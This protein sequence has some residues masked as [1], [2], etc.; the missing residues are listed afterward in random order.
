MNVR[1]AQL[2]SFTDGTWYNDQ[3]EMNEYTVKLWLITNTYSEQEQNIAIR[4]A[5]YF[6]FDQLKNTI[7]INQSDGPKAK[8]LMKVGLNVT[9]LPGEPA[10]QLI[11]IMLFYKLNAIMEDRIKAIEI[12]IST[13]DGVVY[14]HNENE[15]SKDLIQP[16]WWTTIDLSHS[17]LE[18][19]SS[20]KVLLITHNTV[21]RDLDLEWPEDKV[22]ADAGNVV[23]FADFKNSDEAE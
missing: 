7:F 4:R 15:S 17:D 6:V 2:L 23:V 20:D 22:D 11:G 16:E 19:A 14:L 18:P 21:W 1:I 8:E 10:D 12:E 5:R 9:T 13:G 3:L